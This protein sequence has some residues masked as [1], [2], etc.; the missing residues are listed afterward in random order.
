MKQENQ[1]ESL[2]NCI[3]ELQQ[4]AC[5]RKEELEDA[6]HGFLN[7]EENNFAFKMNYI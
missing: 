2:H 4:Q 6:H 7:L 1:V 5:A 3:D